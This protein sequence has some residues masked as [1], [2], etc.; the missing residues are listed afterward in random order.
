MSDSLDGLTNDVPMVPALMDQLR[1]AIARPILSVWDRQFDDVRT[2]RRISERP[3]DTFVV[4]MKQAHTFVAESC[5]ES[6]D[7]NGRRITDEIGVMGRGKNTMRVRR[8][9]LHRPGAEDVVALTNLLDQA[10]FPAGELLGLYKLRWGIE[11]VFQQVTE[12]FSL[13]HLIGSQP[14][15]VLFQF[16]Y[17]LL[18][19]NLVQVVKAY[20]AADGRVL[21][22][23]VST[24]YLFADIKKE[25]IAWAYH[26]D[27]KWP[28]RLRDEEQMRRRLREL[29]HG[30]WD[31]IAYKKASDKTP[32]TKPPPT[33]RLHGGHSSVQ[34]VLDGKAKFVKIT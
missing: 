18:L 5:V 31:P 19:Y 14:Q 24:F 1:Q 7:E 32:R 33:R 2:M 27:G 9:T 16:A 15:A 29:L 34:R 17:C 13:Q 25:L 6:M 26:T 30:S 28:Q 10:A 22:T 4:R 23:M 20:V 8:V 21:A 11:Q 12:T 3:G